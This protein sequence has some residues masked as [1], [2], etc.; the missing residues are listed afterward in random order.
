MRR[1]LR[2][3]EA[4]KQQKTARITREAVKRI[5]EIMLDPLRVRRK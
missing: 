3:S 1:V 5:R 2:L 4:K